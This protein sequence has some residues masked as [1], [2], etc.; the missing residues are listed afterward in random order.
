MEVHTDGANRMTAVVFHQA[1]DASRE[2]L[3]AFL[4]THSGD[5]VDVQMASTAGGRW[6]G[7]VFRLKSCFGRGLLLFPGSAPSLKEGAKF[8]LRLAAP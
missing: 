4:H 5:A 3:T 6:R 1:D 7:T 8:R 2:A